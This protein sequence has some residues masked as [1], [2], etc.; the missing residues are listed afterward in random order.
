M[1]RV[2][3]QAHGFEGA[4]QIPHFVPGGDGGQRVV[5][6]T[7]GDLR[8]RP[9]QHPEG[10]GDRSREEHDDGEQQKG[11][12]DPEDENGTVQGRHVRHEFV[13]GEKDPQ[14][15]AARGKGREHHPAAF[16]REEALEGD[17]AA[18]PVDHVPADPPEGPVV[19]R[20]GDGENGLVHDETGQGMGDEGPVFR[21][22]EPVS[23][24]FDADGGDDFLEPPEGDVGRDDPGEGPFPLHRQVKGDGKGG[25]DDV[26]RAF[27]EIGFRPYGT[28]QFPGNLVPVLR[29]IPVGLVGEIGV[30]D[31]IPAFVKIGRVSR[32]AGPEK[33]RF[34][35]D[36][37][38][39]DV[40]VALHDGPQDLQE[41]P[42]VLRGGGFQEHG[43]IP[44]NLFHLS[45]NDVH[46]VHRGRGKIPRAFLHFTDHDPA[47]IEV[48]VSEDEKKDD[49][50]ARQDGRRDSEG[51]SPT[52]L[53][54]RTPGKTP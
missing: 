7:P 3:G 51:D 32:R 9:R 19:S 18:F 22:E 26:S 38:A 4:G 20:L 35:S 25:H 15:P 40:P 30:A 36:G 49:G 54:F 41:R 33:A 27:V 39:V 44:G 50:H 8:R 43:E 1:Y 10:P 47:G 12:D 46:A 11:P 45:Q 23:R 5:Q 16:S 17:E 53:H 42:L 24:V 6:I 34:E 37:R 13:P 2:Q 52:A 29:D 28:F 48:I 31:R 21:N 14:G